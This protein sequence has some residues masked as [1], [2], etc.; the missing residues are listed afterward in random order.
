MIVISNKM[1]QNIRNL[2]VSNLNTKNITIGLTVLGV[3]FLAYNYISN[4][5]TK[6]IKLLSQVHLVPS[7]PPGARSPG[8]RGGVPGRPGEFARLCQERESP[9]F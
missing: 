7:K 9:F 2:S 8:R 6:K 5:K 1:F 4:I 3:S